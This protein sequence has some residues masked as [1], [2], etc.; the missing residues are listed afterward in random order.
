[1]SSGINEVHEIGRREFLSRFSLAITGS[2]L[3]IS[4]GR[5]RCASTDLSISAKPILPTIRL[6]DHNV[7]RLIVGS[8]PIS[9]YSYL[10]PILDKH[11]RDYFTP[12]RIVEFLWACEREGINTHQFSRPEEMADVFRRLRVLSQLLSLIMVELLTGCL[13]RAKAV[14]YM[15]LSNK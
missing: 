13:E 3:A 7:T 15:T 6:G 9:G 4:T 5:G 2:T 12:D 11:M 14:K 1:M 8:N 10:G